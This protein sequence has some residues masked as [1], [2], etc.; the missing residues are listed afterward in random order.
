MFY[1]AKARHF[2]SQKQKALQVQRYSLWQKAQL[3]SQK[4]IDMVIRDYAPRQ[5]IQW[6]SVLK[7]E[8]FSEASDIDLAVIGVALLTF[9]Q[10]FAEAE[11]MTD[12]SLDLVRWEDIHPAFQRILLMKGK[13]I[14]EQ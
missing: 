7:P 14:Y 8:H 9:L 1:Y 4:I 6:G 13:V 2:L 12:F 11:A 3:D 10:L 5:M